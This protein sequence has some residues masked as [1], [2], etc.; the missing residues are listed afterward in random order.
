MQTALRYLITRPHQAGSLYAVNG[1]EPVEFW[2]F[3]AGLIPSGVSIGRAAAAFGYDAA[4]RLVSYPVDTL[5]FD[6]RGVL[7]TAL[8]ETAA[9]NLLSRAIANS[10]TGWALSGAS[11]SD[12]AL[13]ALGLFP[14]IRI[15]SNGLIWHR[16]NHIDE[17]AVTSGMSYH[18]R[19][20]FRFGTSGAI[21]AT[22]RNMAGAVES[23]VKFSVTE[24]TDMGA[25]AGP[26][27]NASLTALG[28]DDVYRLDLNITPNYSGTLSIGLGPGSAT[29]GATVTLLGAQF[30][31]GTV[32]TSFINSVGSALTR[33][34]DSVTWAA[35]EGSYDLRIIDSSGTAT[36]S[37]SV[38]V[39]AGWAPHALPFSPARVLLY[40]T[41][42]L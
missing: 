6:A 4:G 11:G 21:L 20:F 16:L 35:P 19:A 13:N 7:R 8:F 14:G 15:T 28:V 41:G 26:I 42:T 37:L 12:L 25:G 30:E 2:D 34:V 27:A 31:A 38:S 36:D 5:R 9:T 33:P 23:R 3:D 40:P 24:I 39:G 22:L 32:G 1:I 29:S 10:S 17:P 18:L